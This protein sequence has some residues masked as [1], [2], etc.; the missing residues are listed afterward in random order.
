VKVKIVACEKVG[1]GGTYKI[2]YEMENGKVESINVYG[3]HELNEATIIRKI[4]MHEYMK[5]KAKE[6]VGKTLEI[7]ERPPTEEELEFFGEV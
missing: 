4:Q 2:T 6:I 3:F 5:R 1:R 7:P